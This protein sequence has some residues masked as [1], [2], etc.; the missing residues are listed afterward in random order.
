M[1]VYVVNFAKNF[2]PR[3]I[4]YKSYAQ[5]VKICGYFNL[6]R[7]CIKVL[8]IEEDENKISFGI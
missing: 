4:G 1:I 7:K 8:Y 2:R 3:K 6:P 5:A